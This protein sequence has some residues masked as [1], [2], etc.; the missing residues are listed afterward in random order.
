[1]KMQDFWAQTGPFALFLSFMPIYMPKIKVRYQSLS[2]ILVIKESHW[3]RAIFG[4]SV[5]TRFS[6]ACS[7]CRMLRNHKYFHFT[8]IPDTTND[9]IFS[10]VQKPYFWAIFDHFRK[11]LQL[12]PKNPTP[13]HTTVYGPLTPC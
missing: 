12:F 5:R 7:F 2:E 8:Q 1:M 4:Y 9:M 13:S 11:K 10:R 3:R 6:Q